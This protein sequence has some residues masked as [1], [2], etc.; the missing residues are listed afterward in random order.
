[1]IIAER[2]LG[3]WHAE[4]M[5]YYSNLAMLENLEGNPKASLRFL[6]HVMEMW[7]VI[8]GRGHP[9]LTTV[10]VSANCVFSVRRDGLVH[11]TGVFLVICVCSPCGE[12]AGRCFAVY[13]LTAAYCHDGRAMSF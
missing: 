7:D 4:T 8:Y 5:V 9:E 3:V 11:L 2:T 12:W 13:A 1:M 10:L 6:R